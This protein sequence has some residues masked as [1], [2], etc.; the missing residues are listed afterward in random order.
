LS[1]NQYHMQAA[2]GNVHKPLAYTTPICFTWMLTA[3]FHHTWKLLICCAPFKL[4]S[5]RSQPYTWAWPWLAYISPLSYNYL[6][7]CQI[8]ACHQLILARVREQHAHTCNHS[9]M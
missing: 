2:Y 3:A 7:H 1:T 8:A 6:P 9:P 4:I 5:A